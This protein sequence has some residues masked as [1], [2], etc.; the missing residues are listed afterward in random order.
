MPTGTATKDR[1]S[2][3]PGAVFAKQYRLRPTHGTQ[4]NDSDRS[5]SITVPPELVDRACREYGLTF[6]QFIAKFLGEWQ[7]DTESI[8]LSFVKDA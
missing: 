1:H 5:V 7:Y 8:R 6:K 3:Q 2:A 4:S